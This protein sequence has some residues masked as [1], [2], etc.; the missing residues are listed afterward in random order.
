MRDPEAVRACDR[1]VDQPPALADHETTRRTSPISANSQAASATQIMTC[2]IHCS[3]GNSAARP[4]RALAT[5]YM[6][7]GKTKLHMIGS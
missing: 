2:E 5:A 6:P 7:S 4:S 1:G 3:G